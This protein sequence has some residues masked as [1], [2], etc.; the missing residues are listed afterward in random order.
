MGFVMK[1]KDL[2]FTCIYSEVV[3]GT[4]DK[5]PNI[6]V[7]KDAPMALIDQEIPM[8]SEL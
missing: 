6:I 2:H 7:T 3:S 5:R 4:E 1:T 8:L